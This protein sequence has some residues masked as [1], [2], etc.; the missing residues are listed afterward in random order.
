MLRFI[1]IV[2]VVAA[3]IPL[4]VERTTSPCDALQKRLVTMAARGSNDP[5]LV[6][7]LGGLAQH[8]TGSGL[9]EAAAKQK[10]PKLPAPLACYVIYYEAYYRSIV[11]SSYVLGAGPWNGR[12]DLA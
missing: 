9:A 1:L 5:A 3:A 8:L 11:E 12:A 7:I 6:E 2:L 4:L 10:Y